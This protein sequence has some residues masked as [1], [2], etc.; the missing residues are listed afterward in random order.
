LVA[1]HYSLDVFR[2][3]VLIKF[4]ELSVD[5]LV[6]TILKRPFAILVILPQNSKV[7][8][9]NQNMQNLLQAIR[10]KRSKLAVI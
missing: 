9:E 7:E 5:N 1:Q 4:E 2:K 6:T 3:I 10:G 8:K